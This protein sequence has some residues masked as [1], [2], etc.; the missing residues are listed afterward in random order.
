[1]PGVRAHAAVL[2]GEVIVVE[3]GE[4]G[5][6]N[7]GIGARE[8]RAA[9]HVADAP[10]RQIIADAA[11]QQLD[12]RRVA[13]FRRHAGA[14]ELQKLAAVPSGVCLE[15]GEVVFGGTVETA[16][17]MGDTLAEQSVCA[18]DTRAVRSRLFNQQVIAEPVVGIDVETARTAARCSPHVA[19]KN[20]IA[21][22]LR[23]ANVGLA[24]CKADAETCVAGRVFN[25]T[26]GVSPGCVTMADFA[27]ACFGQASLW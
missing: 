4:R 21:Q 15:R 24:V 7:I 23:G 22:R 3:I 17:M 16:V 10:L 12:R 18:D 5:G 1:V 26:H 9:E 20:L 8:A 27:R 13:I 11:P 2:R 25:E 14:P 19:E 6:V